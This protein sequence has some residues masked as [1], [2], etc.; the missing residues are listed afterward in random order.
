MSGVLRATVA[1]AAFQVAHVVDHSVHL[2]SGAGAELGLVGLTG[3]LTT[4]VLLV[5][6][7]RRSAWVP[8]LAIALGLGAAIG[9]PIVHVLPHWGVF[10]DPYPSNGA[11]AIDWVLLAAPWASAVWL[12]VEGL[13]LRAVARAQ[14]APG[15]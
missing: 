6:I 8:D 10:S 12:A 5:L 2:K 3:G 15:A 7:A 13:R 14:P 4:V 1:Y 9:F 11:D